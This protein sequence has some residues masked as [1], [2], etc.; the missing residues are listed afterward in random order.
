MKTGIGQELL[1]TPAGAGTRAQT[2][3]CYTNVPLAASPPQAATA[4]SVPV[5]DTSTVGSRGERECPGQ[6]ARAGTAAAVAGVEGTGSERRRKRVRR[7]EEEKET[8][9]G[10]KGGGTDD[11]TVA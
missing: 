6:L 7:R 1:F 8:Q 9:G 11:G 3:L 10:K 4:T 5:S 2:H